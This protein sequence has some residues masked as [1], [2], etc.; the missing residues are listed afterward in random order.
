MENNEK[1]LV[2]IVLKS[3]EYH[4][5]FNSLD[6]RTQEKYDY[7]VNICKRKKLLARSL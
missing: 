1:N 4:E 3:N 2:R 6:R 5:Y 7:T